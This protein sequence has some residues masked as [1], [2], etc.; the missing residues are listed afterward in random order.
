MNINLSFISTST[1]INL[2]FS[3][4]KY[5][6]KNNLIFNKNHSNFEKVNKL[7]QET[8]TTDLYKN[9]QRVTKDVY[10]QFIL[11]Q[12]KYAHIQTWSNNKL[13]ISR[14][15]AIYE[16]KKLNSTIEN[17]LVTQFLNNPEDTEAFE[18][19]ENF[20]GASLQ[21]N[22]DSK[23]KDRLFLFL[24]KK[25]L[26]I[27]KDGRVLAWKVITSNYK[28][29]Y[30]RSIDNSVGTTVSIPRNQVDSDDSSTCS[31]GLHVCS[32]DYLSHFSSYG[33]IVVQVEIDVKDIIAI[34]IDYEGDKIRVCKYKVI[35]EVG[36]WGKTVTAD[37][38]PE[39]TCGFSATV[40]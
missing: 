22:L 17:F 1:F 16:G 25:D 36:V 35:S 14:S 26:K 12:D 7:L 19:W 37:K 11:Y 18:A 33:D 31:Y 34:P 4:K 13:T 23:I 5:N 10:D 29:K 3:R 8:I 38:V 15:G 28:D 39:V 24:Q 20:L 2:N 30:S 21:E 32:F 40:S 9:K 27:N 6:I